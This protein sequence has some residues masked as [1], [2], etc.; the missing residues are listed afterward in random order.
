MAKSGANGDTVRD[1]VCVIP[2]HILWAAYLVGLAR[3]P[4]K[5]FVSHAVHSSTV[6]EANEVSHRQSKR[7]GGPW[8]GHR[9]GPK[10]TRPKRGRHPS[11]ASADTALSMSRT[12]KGD[13]CHI[14][15]ET[16]CRIGTITRLCSAVIAARR[17]RAVVIWEHSPLRTVSGLGSGL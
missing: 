3:L 14:I 11:A 16:T 6:Y 5:C 9:G 17:P 8:A 2:E 10:R 15:V 13:H 4:Q 12:N 7:D 1:T